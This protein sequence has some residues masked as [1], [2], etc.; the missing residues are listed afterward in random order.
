MKT[1][2]QIIVPCAVN[3]VASNEL[4]CLVRFVR[5]RK[6]LGQLIIQRSYLDLLRQ[7]Q[8]E[9]NPPPPIYTNFII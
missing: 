3:I 2:L 7:V 5:I 6:M 9:N 1:V 8:Y 4:E